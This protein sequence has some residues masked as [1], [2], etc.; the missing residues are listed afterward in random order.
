MRLAKTLKK[1]K[2]EDRT[3]FDHLSVHALF[4]T[5]FLNQSF[6]P[7]YI[8][9]PLYTKVITDASLLKTLVTFR[10]YVLPSY[11]A[12]HFPPPPPLLIHPNVAIH[13]I[14]YTVRSCPST[15][16][17]APVTYSCTLRTFV[18]I[19]QCATKPLSSYYCIFYTCFTHISSNHIFHACSLLCNQ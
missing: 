10:V 11:F 17:S 18:T 9:K 4:I 3:L 6:L 15:K 8:N 13:A 16:R 2:K 12:P 7:I 5:T 19:S 1:K 14:P